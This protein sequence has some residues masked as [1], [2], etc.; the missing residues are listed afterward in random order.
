MKLKEIF[1]NNILIP[2]IIQDYRTKE[3][4][5][6]GYMNEEALKKTL[7]TGFVWFWGRS[8]K[9][10][11]MKGETS[12][13]TLKLKEMY[14]DCDKDALLVKVQLIGENVCHTGNKICFYQKI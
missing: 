10:L 11:W 4:F 3:I 8:R 9:R 13:N 12:G 14:M 7:E 1:K 2:A 6:L 5:M